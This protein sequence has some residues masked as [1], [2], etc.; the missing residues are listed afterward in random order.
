MVDVETTLRSYHWG[1]LAFLIILSSVSAFQH[2]SNA[3]DF[4]IA[5]VLHAFF[6]RAVY[7][8]VIGKAMFLGGVIEKDAS[9][10]ERRVGALI[11]LAFL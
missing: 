8:Y 6:G 1:V 4:F 11:A 5:L 7:C 9:R 10:L 2:I 3:S